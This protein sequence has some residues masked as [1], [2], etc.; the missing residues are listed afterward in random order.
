MFSTWINVHGAGAQR[1]DPKSGNP[2]DWEGGFGPQGDE[3]RIYNYVRAV[4]TIESETSVEDNPE[5][6]PGNS[7][8]KQNYPNPFN[9][10]TTFAFF[11]PQAGHVRLTVSNTLGQ[12]VA[13]ICDR[14]LSAGNHEIIW[15]AYNLASGVYFI[16]M[17]TV[18]TIRT[19]QMV[20]ME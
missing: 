12:T 4:R 6:I 1:S 8:L 13:V 15:H 11:L 9:P 17:R 20:L 10:E 2:A 18:N 19:K 7:E 14:N 3:I 16:S 5:T